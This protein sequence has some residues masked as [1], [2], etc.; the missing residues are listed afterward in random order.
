MLTL[1]LVRRLR[2]AT[3]IT[4]AAITSMDTV[5]SVNV[6]LVSNE[7]VMEPIELDEPGLVKLKKE[8]DPEKLFNLFK[9]NAHNKV[10]IE[11][12]FAFEDMVSP[13]AGAG[14]FDYIE[15]L[16]EQQKTLPQGRR[17]GFVIGL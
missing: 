1:R 11:N 9:A 12:R 10:V 7:V 8:R 17:E 4:A 15:N 16:L 2:T 14:R 3:Y 6:K 13:L 5:N